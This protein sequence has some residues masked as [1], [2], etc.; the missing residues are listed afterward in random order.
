LSQLLSNAA[1]RADKDIT[2]SIERETVVDS[3]Q[4]P[5]K[6]QSVS[7]I[8]KD[9]H[10]QTVQVGV[11]LKASSWIRVVADGKTQFEGTL[12]EGTH[13]VWKAQEQLTVKT[14]NAGGVLMSVNQQAAKEMGELGEEEEIKIAAQPQL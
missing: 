14:T 4:K 11:T 3:Q 8:I 1:L 10:N 12:P 6:T 9:K 7:D 2:P 5:I 13:R